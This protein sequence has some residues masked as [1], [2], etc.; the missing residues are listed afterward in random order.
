MIDAE[1]TTPEPIK[2]KKRRRTRILIGVIAVLVLIRIVLPYV[3]LR[4]AND[5]LAKIPGYYGHIDDLNLA[6]IRGAYQIEKLDLQKV[7]SVSQDR[8]PFISATLID[9]S[10]EWRAL[11][12][13]SIVGEVEATEPRLRFTKGKAEPEDVQADT[14][15][16]AQVFDDFMPLKLNRVALING[17]LEYVDAGSA[18]PLDMALTDLNAEALNLSSVIDKAEVLPSTITATAHVYGGALDL[19]MGL[20]ALSEQTTFDL[21]LKVEGIDLTKVNDFFQAYANFDVNKGNMSVYT[22]LATRE[23]A[24]TGYVKPVIKDLDVLGKED[25]EDNFFRKLWEGFV[26]TAGVLLNNPNK[27]QVATKVPLEGRLDDP[28]VGSWVAISR[29]LANAFVKALQ[30]TL[31]QEVTIGDVNKESEEKE[32]GFLKKVFGKDKKDDKEDHKKDKKK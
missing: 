23:G 29:V 1:A 28:K 32:G 26:G 20:D 9:I 12:K 31:D 4:V 17:R 14:A 3:L 11:F 8:T 19:K 15:S 24:F 30:P 2:S 27:K 22:E 25:R 7:D 13:G 6:L 16:L 18:P 10:V 5:R 21:D